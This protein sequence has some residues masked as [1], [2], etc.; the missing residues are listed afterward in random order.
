MNILKTPAALLCVQC[1]KYM[2]A[3]AKYG[4]GEIDF[5]WYPQSALMMILRTKLDS[6][7]KEGSKSPVAKRRRLAMLGQSEYE[8]RAPTNHIM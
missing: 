8:A 1:F 6:G 7:R 5:P 2:L 3:H 4:G